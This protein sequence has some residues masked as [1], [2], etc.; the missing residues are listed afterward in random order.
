MPRIHALPDLLISQ[1]AAGEVVERPAS[2]LKEL[3]E[4]SLDA[5]AT[6][7]T[8]SSKKAACKLIRVADDGGGID[9]RRP[10]AGAGAPRHQQDRQ[11]S[12]TWN[13]SPATAFAARRWPR[14]PRWRASRSPAARRRRA[15]AWRRC[16]DGATAAEPAALA[17]GTVIEVADLYFNTPARRK[18][19]KTEATEYAHCDEVLRRMALARPDVAFTLAHN[20]SVK[21]RLPA[22]DFAAPRARPARRRLPRPGARGRRR[23]RAAAPDRLRRPARL[24]ARPRAT[25]STSSSMAA[26]CATSCSPTPP[27]RPMPTCCTAPA[28]RPT[29]CSS[30]STR[31]PSTSTC[32]RPR[33]RCASAMRAACTS[34]SSTRCTRALAAAASPHA[35]PPQ[36]PPPAPALPA[37][38]RQQSL[39]R[40]G[41]GATA[42]RP[43]STSPRQAFAEPRQRRPLPASTATPPLGYALAQLHGVYILAQNDAGLVLVDMHAAHERILYERLKNALDAG[44]PPTQPLLVPALFAASAKEMASRRGAGRSARATRLRQSPPAGPRQLAVRAVPAL[45]AGGDVAALVRALLAELAEH[46]A[47]RVVDARRNE[48]LATM[49]CHGAV[50]AH[51]SLTLPEMNA[52]LREMEATE[53]A[54]QCNHGRPT[55]RAS[56]AW[57]SS[58]AVPARPMMHAA[59]RHPAHGPDRQRQDR[60]GVRAR[61][62]LPG[63]DHQRRFGAG[64]PRHGHRHRQ[65]RRRDAGALPAPPDRPHHARRKATRPRASAPTRCA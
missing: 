1:I 19:L 15:H 24:L 22:A 13:A 55:W 36:P 63:R 16:R 5:G 3:L 48:L 51:R 32:I 29:C 60:A 47:S 30:S 42:T 62:P 46:P 23:G 11:R 10:A 18:F 39:R 54:D 7:S 4:N 28:T 27:A 31:P 6:R 21:R 14:S 61:R 37:P 35:R 41:A 25:R 8:C 52:L 64:L 43:I 12:T 49:A 17:R 9:P 20:G 38:P 50:R 33:P 40:R 53:R 44:P 59:A 45:L 26:S 56:S 57:P 65:A 58:T 2:V 34:S